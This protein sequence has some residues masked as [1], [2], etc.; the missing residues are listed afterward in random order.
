[1]SVKKKKRAQ[2]IDQMIENVRS[3]RSHK[4]I[5]RVIQAVKQSFSEAANDEQE[6]GKKAQ[7]AKHQINK[8]LNSE[9]YMHLLQFFAGELPELVL[10]AS[11]VRQ[12]L[13]KEGG[14]QGFDIKKAYGSC[15]NKSTALLKSYSAN[16]TRL[17]GELAADDS[18]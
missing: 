11:G 13:P 16:M 17:L 15:S 7:K 10:E 14:K 8:A 5:N 4:A 6:E 12:Q 18:L 9:E 3:Q 2:V 1:M